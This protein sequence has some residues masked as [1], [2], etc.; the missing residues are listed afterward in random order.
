[1]VIKEHGPTRNIRT[2]MKNCLLNEIL[3]RGI[4]ENHLMIFKFLNISNQNKSK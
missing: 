3:E 1:M 4:Q 2:P